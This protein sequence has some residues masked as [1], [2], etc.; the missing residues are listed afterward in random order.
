MPKVVAP[1]W[2]EPVKLPPLNTACP[3]DAIEISPD[4]KTLYFYWSPTVGAV[5]AELLT[6]ATGTY[7]ASRVGQ[8]PGQFGSP[9]FY[10]LRA[11]T[12]TGACDGEVSFSPGGAGGADIWVS[13]LTAGIWSEPQNLDAPVNSAGEDLQPAFVKSDPDTIY[14]TSDRNGPS[15]I[16]VSHK[17]DDSWGTPEQIVT[18]YVGEP[19][20]TADGAILY[21]V[22]VLVDSQGVFGADIWYVKREQ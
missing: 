4:G 21:F 3:E 20:L 6:G 18:G 5:P 19:T 17:G 2:S 22:H 10:D 7:T 9:T 8:D 16:F 14:F 11:G 13:T 15:A 12:T 1:G